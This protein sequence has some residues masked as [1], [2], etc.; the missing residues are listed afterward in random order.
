MGER[1]GGGAGE[2]R[3]GVGCVWGEG[4]LALR[5]NPVPDFKRPDLV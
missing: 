3:A 5:A 1:G 2:R 4:G